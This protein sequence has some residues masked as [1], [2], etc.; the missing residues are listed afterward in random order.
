MAKKDVGLLSKVSAPNGGLEAAVKSMF[1][2]LNGAVADAGEAESALDK[3]DS[4]K[5]DA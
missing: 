4:A 3:E 2:S 1:D 5:P